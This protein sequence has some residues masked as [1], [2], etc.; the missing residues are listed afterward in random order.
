MRPMKAMM[1]RVLV[2]LTVMMLS[3]SAVAECSALV[4]SPKMRVYFAPTTASEQIGALVQGVTVTVEAISGDWAR[5][6][7]QGHVGFAQVGDM[8]SLAPAKTRTNHVSPILY[9]TPDDLTPRWGTLDRN[10]TVYLRSWQGDLALVSDKDM[11]I[12]AFIPKNYIG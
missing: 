10:T 4:F 2:V 12:L 6:N 3:V 11:T 9:I 1:K 7:Y 8:L 5:V